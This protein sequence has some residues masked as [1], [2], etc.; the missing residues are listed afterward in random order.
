MPRLPRLRL[1]RLPRLRRLR[2]LRLRGFLRLLSGGCKL[3]TH[4][5]KIDW[6]GST[7]DPANLVFAE[8]CANKCVSPENG[9]RN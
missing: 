5:A 4:E 9:N 6:S 7:I 2:R 8:R 1:P 3:P